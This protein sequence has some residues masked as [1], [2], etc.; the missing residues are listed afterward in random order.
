MEVIGVTQN[1]IAIH[2]VLN[3]V[4]D[5]NN[6]FVIHL[7][8]QKEIDSLPYTSRL[9]NVFVHL[10]SKDF[11]DSKLPA[12]HMLS[13]THHMLSQTHHKN[14]IVI[15]GE[16]QWKDTNLID[17]VWSARF[18]NICLLILVGQKFPCAIRPYM[19]NSLY[20]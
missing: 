20:L 5:N 10:D 1:I 6:D 2:T 8:V 12:T 4:R 18:R 3:R 11:I 9:T 13:Q 19:S 7:V 14:N 17:L 16:N 15:I